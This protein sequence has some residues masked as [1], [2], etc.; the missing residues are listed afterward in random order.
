MNPLSA[1]TL[2]VL[3]LLGPGCRDYLSEEE[4][5]GNTLTDP[6][7]DPRLPTVFGLTAASFVV[8]EQASVV[9][10]GQGPIAVE[11]T[12]G[13]GTFGQGLTE[14]NSCVVTLQAEGPLQPL[15]DSP[16]AQAEIWLA[17]ALAA[18]T[19]EPSQDCAEREP[20]EAWAAVPAQVAGVTWTVGVGP[21]SQDTA[22]ELAEA[23]DNYE[24]LEPFLVGGGFGFGRPLPGPWTDG[25]V[26][27]A[28]TFVTEVDA[29]GMPVLE[30]GDPKLI[31]AADVPTDAGVVSASYELSGVTLLSPLELLTP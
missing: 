10:R 7:R 27:S 9:G 1:R 4:P 17:F 8:D 12:V 21:L 13:D 11:I 2:S 15:Q 31:E 26:D 6:D 22:G 18:G 25:W 5:T 30:D 19:A 3:L 24:E 29:Q 23:W 14:D 16:S 28:V 20:V